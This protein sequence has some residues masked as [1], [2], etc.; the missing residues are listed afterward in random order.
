MNRHVPPQRRQMQVY[1]RMKAPIEARPFALQFHVVQAI[2]HCQEIPTGESVYK[3]ALEEL[4][5]GS[6][7]E[8]LD[9]L[10]AWA[11]G[12]VS[13]ELRGED[14]EAGIRII[15]KANGIVNPDEEYPHLAQFNQEFLNNN[16][17]LALIFSL[18][19]DA[20][21]LDLPAIDRHRGG[22]GLQAAYERPRQTQAAKREGKRVQ[23]LLKQLASFDE[24]AMVAQADE[25]VV[26]RHVYQGHL[27]RYKR[28]EE[29]AGRSLSSRRRKWFREFDRAFGYLPPERG[30]PRKAA[31]PLRSRPLQR[32]V[33]QERL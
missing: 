11:K 28:Q 9:D 14:K 30:R 7:A 17:Q 27:P 8:V 31:K 12:I 24:P 3:D 19:V 32:K 15:D 29:L 1:P 22:F 4:L 6:L 33:R 20:A 5:N 21:D 26:Y 2:R 23:A 25:Y 18:V 10:D 13:E 16:G